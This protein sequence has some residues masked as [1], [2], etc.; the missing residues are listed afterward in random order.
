M[1]G[2][3]NSILQLGFAGISLTVF[4]QNVAGIVKTSYNWFKT[5]TTRFSKFL[6]NLPLV[7]LIPFL[8][9][10]LNFKSLLKPATA[11]GS[12]NKKMYYLRL[13]A[14]VGK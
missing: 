3:L 4:V 11:A 14:L 10:K 1:L 9:A 8:F 2:G 13:L 12:K 6:I 5:V 7:R